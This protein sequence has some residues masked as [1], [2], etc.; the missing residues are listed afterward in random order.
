MSHP[1][2]AVFS[3]REQSKTLTLEDSPV[4]TYHISVPTLTGGGYGVRRVHQYYEHMERTWLARWQKQT[5]LLACLNQSHQQQTSHPFQPWTADLTG[6]GQLLTEHL[7]S[8]SFT[9]R[10]CHGDGRPHL[11][12]TCDLWDLHLGAPVPL[13]QLMRGRLW[14]KKLLAQARCSIEDANK[15][16]DLFL[17]DDWRR[18]LRHRIPHLSPEGLTLYYPQCTISPAA[19]GIPAIRLGF[20][21]PL[22]K[23]DFSPE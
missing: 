1:S 19:E 14:R 5:Y 18:H 4:L 15:Q 12:R 11:T 7:F 9:C 8:V 20:V 22:G 2:P 3:W 16:G 21:P 10:E 13:R 6:E 23:L 17:N